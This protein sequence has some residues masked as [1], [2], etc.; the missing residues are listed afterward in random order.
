MLTILPQPEVGRHRKLAP[1]SWSSK[2]TFIWPSFGNWLSKRQSVGDEMTRAV[3]R[4]SQSETG[5]AWLAQF[6]SEDVT[7]AAKLL[8]AMLLLNDTEV[9]DSI[10][11]GID[12][13]AEEWDGRGRSLALYAE[14]EFDAGTA[15]ESEELAD[16]KGHVRRRAVRYSGPVKPT[17][18]KMR[19][20]SEGTVAHLISQ[21]VERWPG[22]LKNHPGPKGIRA[23]SSPVGAIV[24]VSDLIGSGIRVNKMLDKFWRVPSVKSWVSGKR[25]EF[26]VVAAAGTLKGIATVQSHRLRP[27]VIAERVVPTVRT[28]KD[29]TLANEW[30]RLIA[31]YGPSGGRGGVDRGGYGGDAALVAL[32]SR[33]PNN[34]PAIVH[35]SEGRN[36]SALFEGPAPA[37]LRPIF[38]VLEDAE[39]VKS[40]AEAI[41][42]ELAQDLGID[43]A[44]LVV[45]LSAPPSLLR[46]RDIVALAATTTLSRSEVERIVDRAANDGLLTAEGRLT[47]A[48][49]QMLWANRRGERHK[50]TIATN[51]DPYYPQGLR[52]PRGQV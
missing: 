52:I 16:A 30:R 49:Q 43:N 29:Q 23:K 17:R 46:R 25:I 35:Q 38:R 8:D 31:T 40:A 51:T 21:L 2:T 27:R 42:V 1:W 45:V 22:L 14:R 32:S 47:E 24:V 19:V 34:T 37:D 20:G 26:V 50:A 6:R 12:K 13:L 36:W 44:K 48:G 3:S 5:R 10:R 4:L 28:W 39:L 18:G 15:F 9:A 33:I 41:G 11:D 7:A